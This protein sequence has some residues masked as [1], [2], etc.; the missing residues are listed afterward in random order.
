MVAPDTTKVLAGLNRKDLFVCVHEQ[1]MTETAEL[2][3]IVIPATMFLEHDDMYK[4][5][6]H[7]YL[8][9]TR[10]VIEPYEECRSNHE[11]LCALAERLGAEHA[12]FSMTAW[13]LM[14]QCLR[15]SGLGGVDDA[16]KVRWLDFSKSTEEL[17]FLNGFANPDRKFRFAPDWAALGGDYEAMPALPDHMDNTD[18]TGPE[19]P[20]RLVTSPARRFLNSTFTESETSRRM[21]RRPTALI[22]PADCLNLGLAD[23]EEVRLGNCRADVVVHVRSFDGLQPGVVVVEGIWPNEAFVE[24]LGINA[25]TSSDPAPPAGG[26]AFHDTAVWMRSEAK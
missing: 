17:N 12:G 25:L 14:D 3:D 23:G 2:A 4:G 6:G 13:Q 9:V 19:H 7:S 10:K 18:P 15:A 11:V 16:Y 8:H 20:F 5:G 22:N 21:E 24:G 26:A 1:F